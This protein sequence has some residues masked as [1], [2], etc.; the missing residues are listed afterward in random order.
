MPDVLGSHLLG[1]K[2]PEPDERDY[3]LADYLDSDVAITG[4]DL[5]RA[6]SA[7][8]NKKGAAQT[9]KDA[10]KALVSH[11]RNLENSVGP[12]PMP[13]ASVLWDDSDEVLDQGQTGHC[14]GFGFAQFG[15]TEPVDDN[16][17]NSDGHAL[18]Y[19][20]KVI[21][22]EPKAED[23]SSVHSGVK[24]LKNRG[25][26][27][28]YAWASTVDEIKAWVLSKG[29]VIVGTDW[30]NDQ[31]KPDADGFVTPTGGIA[32][33]HCYLI[34]GWD[35]S[36]NIT[37]LNSWGSSWG[38]GGRFHMTADN[39]GHLINSDFEACAVV[40][41]PSASIETSIHTEDEGGLLE[42]VVK[43]LS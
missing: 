34:I 6:L 37:F 8:L 31:F 38:K 23:G 15:N 1:W 39:F 42:R 20:A 19:E 16:W 5:D 9:T 17:S 22:G 29:P 33:G 21:D 32:G 24:A 25:R 41:L 2:A 3:K 43:W 12:Q 18:Y 35:D 36:N 40:E 13:V 30:Y 28:T 27:G 7:L 10:V 4:D 26:V 14:V 11:V